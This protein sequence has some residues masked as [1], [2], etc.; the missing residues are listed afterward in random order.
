M[1][2]GTDFTADIFLSHERYETIYALDD[3]IDEQRKSVQYY[4]EKILMQCAAGLPAEAK[5]CEGNDFD[6]IDD[7]HRKATE[8]LD[9]LIE[10]NNHLCDLLLLREDWDE[11]EGKWK[12]AEVG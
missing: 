5:D 8:W 1:G 7:V 9:L 10:E 4:R 3:A 12:T 2:W 6:P 11:K